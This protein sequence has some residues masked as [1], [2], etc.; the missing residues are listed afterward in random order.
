[1]GLVLSIHSSLHFFASR[2]LE[3]QAVFCA[4]LVGQTAR[5]F[6][7]NIPTL[8]KYAFSSASIPGIGWGNRVVLPE[9]RYSPQERIDTNRL[10]HIH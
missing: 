9:W 5:W 1:M 7:E 2:P 3:L 10:R 6:F 8:F 4:L